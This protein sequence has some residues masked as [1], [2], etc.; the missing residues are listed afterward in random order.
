M[1]KYTITVVGEDKIRQDPIK[2]LLQPFSF[3]LHGCGFQ[4][5][6]L[7]ENSCGNRV[8]IDYELIYIL[9]GSGEI[10]IEGMKYSTKAGMLFL[11][12]PFTRHY[13]HSSSEDPH[14]DYWIHF[15]LE[16]FWN[17]RKLI[18]AIT[19]DGGG[20]CVQVG[21]H[22]QLTE[23]FRQLYEE[24]SQENAGF[25][26]MSELLFRQILIILM[27]LGRKCLDR[28]DT[29]R[30]EVIRSEVIVQCAM[31]YVNRHLDKSISMN[32]IADAAGV[33]ESYL[34]KCFDKTVGITPNMFV[35]K[36]KARRAKYLIETT[37]LSLTEIASGLGFSNYYYFSTF[38]KKMYGIAPRMFKQAKDR[39]DKHL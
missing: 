34:Y 30:R 36:L 18:H 33:S 24:L 12:P 8:I 3:S 9:D 27:R 11:I 37:D 23:L 31:E 14:T 17:A 39:I 4:E 1:P 5:G 20:Y 6:D 28:P 38:F 16:P 7:P 22:S 15:D 21:C 19:D 26:L 35:Q 25:A 13:I 32:E 2:E 29:A 10:G